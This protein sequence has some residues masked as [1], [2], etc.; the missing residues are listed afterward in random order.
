M[1]VTSIYDY[2]IVGSVSNAQLSNYAPTFEIEKHAMIFQYV[3]T[4]ILNNY[5]HGKQNGA[6]DRSILGNHDPVTYLYIPCI[7][8]TDRENFLVVLDATSKK[9]T[10]VYTVDQALNI[11]STGKTLKTEDNRDVTLS[12]IQITKS[13]FTYDGK[14]YEVI[15]DEVGKPTNN[16]SLYMDYIGN[17]EE[18]HF[19][20]VSYVVFSESYIRSSNNA[21]VKYYHIALIDTSNNVY[22]EV[23]I[24]VPNSFDV[25]NKF[26]TVY[27]SIVGY[28]Y[29]KDSTDPT[30]V[31]VGCYGINPTL[32][33]TTN[34][35]EYTL[36]YSVQILPSAYY[37]FYID[38]PGGY[39]AQATITDPAKASV[40]KASGTPDYQGHGA[41]Y[42]GAYLPP[43]SIVAQ[44][45]PVTIN[46]TADSSE[47]TNNWA[48]TSTD[49]YTR[50]ASLDNDS[51]V[52]N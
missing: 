21:N 17:P 7:S 11:S 18:N 26:S 48:I 47:E 43:S 12:N 22:F 27:L 38:L 24:I 9:L 32:N 51:I 3:T 20:Y 29:Q 46:V 45:V 42:D 41:D 37:Y 16:S 39:K 13:Q 49:V 1:S 25:T 52:G 23:K 50:K 40:R 10:T 2:Y 30:R 31:E 4:K 6:S 44:R 34:N 15:K 35:Y 14:T 19:W 36:R 28:H 5:G 33:T 8:G